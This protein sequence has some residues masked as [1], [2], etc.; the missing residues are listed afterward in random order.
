MEAIKLMI[1]EEQE[2]MFLKQFYQIATKAIEKA[3]ENA[4]M[5]RE[6]LNQ[7]E[8]SLKTESQRKNLIQ[9]MKQ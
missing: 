5:T 7:K 1:S 3:Q 4:G 8:I 6:Y 2:E 9:I